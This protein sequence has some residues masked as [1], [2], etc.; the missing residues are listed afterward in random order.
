MSRTITSERG[1][2]TPLNFSQKTHSFI[3]QNQIFS[4]EIF[5]ASRKED[6]ESYS[7]MPGKCILG[8][9]FLNFMG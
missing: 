2:L 7:Q 6:V 1:K 3:A 5:L 8:F 9:E 4:Q